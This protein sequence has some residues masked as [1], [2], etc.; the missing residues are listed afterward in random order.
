MPAELR[1][2]DREVGDVHPMIARASEDAV[3]NQLAD[4][5]SE[6]GSMRL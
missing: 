2:G 6:L 1:R 5:K 3:S 4:L